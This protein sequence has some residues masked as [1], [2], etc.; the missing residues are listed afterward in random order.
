[1]QTGRLHSRGCT[2]S[3]Y[4][5][6]FQSLNCSRVC[7][8]PA[9]NMHP[10]PQLPLMMQPNGSMAGLQSIASSVPAALSIKALSLNDT[11]PYQLGQPAGLQAGTM[12]H[13]LTSMPIPK[14]EASCSPQSAEPVAAAPPL[15]ANHLTA[16]PPPRPPPP[17]G[18]PPFPLTGM[19]PGT[20]AL[21]G[22]GPLYAY[23]HMMGLSSSWNGHD[24]YAPS[25]GTTPLGCSPPSSG[26]SPALR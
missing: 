19:S 4:S 8:A 13:Q 7:V 3:N 10:Q 17:P 14:P 25:P 11:M 23:P 21:L 18:L 15:V 22:I 12:A 16:G 24:P 26:T 1:M 2:F 20:A 9:E 6:Q 5:V